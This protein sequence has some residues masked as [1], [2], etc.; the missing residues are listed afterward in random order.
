MFCIFSFCILYIVYQ[1]TFI[2]KNVCLF[3]NLFILFVMFILKN[4]FW[5]TMARHQSV[6]RHFKSCRIYHN[7]KASALECHHN[8]VITTLYQLFLR[9]LTF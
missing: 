4:G 7:Y 8:V 6:G 1:A 2:C 9:A 5:Q 3:T